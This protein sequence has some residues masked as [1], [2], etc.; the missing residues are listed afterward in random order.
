MRTAFLLVLLGDYVHAASGGAHDVH[1]IPWKELI[2][3]QTVNVTIFLTILFILLRKPI[4][5]HFSGKVQDFEQ[6][7]KDAEAAKE[8]AQATHADVQLKLEELKSSADQNL[9]TAHADAEALKLKIIDE[10]KSHAERLEKEARNSATHEL[11][12]AMFSLRTELLNKSVDIARDEV[13]SNTN[14][15]VEASLQKEFVEKAKE[16]RV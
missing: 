5:N 7:K 15:S 10:A 12:K 13:K 1:D 6:A 2:I 4:K 8:Q 16:V 14:S 11:Q 9:K 3:P